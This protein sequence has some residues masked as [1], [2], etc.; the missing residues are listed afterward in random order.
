MKIGD[1]VRVGGKHP[2]LVIAVAHR[3]R[4]NMPTEARVQFLS[5]PYRRWVLVTSV[6]VLSEN[7]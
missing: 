7:W 4:E 6:E 2:A 1:I 5:T 3:D